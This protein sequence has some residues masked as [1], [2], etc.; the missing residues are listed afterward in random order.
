MLSSKRKT[1]AVVSWWNGDY[2]A[3]L[4]TRDATKELKILYENN[5]LLAV[6]KPAGLLTQGPARNQNTLID[7][8]KEWIKIKYEKPGNV[9]AGLI[10]RLD[11]PVAGVVLIARTSKAASRLSKEM[12]ERKIDKIY[13]AIVK[14]VPKNDEGV[15]EGYLRKR[16]TD[17]RMIVFRME[18]EK[19]TYAKLSYKLIE[20]RDA[21]SLLQITPETGRRHQIRA[22]LAHAGTP[23]WGDCKYGSGP[24]LR[25]RI[26]LLA[27]RITFN[28]PTKGER[29][30]V[31][32]LVPPNW[33]WP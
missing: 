3:R 31:E 20:T 24:K 32:S 14:G 18:R 29:I 6:F 5:H 7:I 30:T 17:K 16:E 12:R 15:L 22:L 2:L 23:V 26:A 28:H 4:S 33:P 27:H 9:Y 8:V 1:K 13:L 25:G 11:R 21:K 10:H 19:T